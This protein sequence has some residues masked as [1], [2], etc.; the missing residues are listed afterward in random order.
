MLWRRTVSGIPYRGMSRHRA[1][2]FPLLVGSV[3][4]ACLFP[5]EGRPLLVGYALQLDS[6][7]RGRCTYA[8]RLIGLTLVGRQ[9]YKSIPVS[10]SRTRIHGESPTVKGRAFFVSGIRDPQLVNLRCY[11]YPIPSDLNK[12]T[13]LIDPK[14]LIYKKIIFIQ[15]D[16][17][18]FK[19]FFGAKFPASINDC[20]SY[21]IER[22]YH[23][24]PYPLE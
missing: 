1:S 5:L 9:T 4:V 2:F 23:R 19:N 14:C 22:E 20:F 7:Y 11:T 21:G 16:I 24:S 3:H 15:A 6:I 12:N 8:P 18:T 10:T 17:S 13:W